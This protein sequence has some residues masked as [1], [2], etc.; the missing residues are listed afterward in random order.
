MAQ[1]VKNLT[2]AAGVRSLEFLVN[3]KMKLLII[4][5]QSLGCY[6]FIFKF[7]KY[8]MSTYYAPGTVLGDDRGR[9]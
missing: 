1:W 7:K 2:A 5:I 8:L 4:V 6:L 9:K 3:S